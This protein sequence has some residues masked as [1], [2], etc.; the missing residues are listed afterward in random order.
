MVS[1]CDLKALLPIAGNPAVSHFVT[2]D[3]ANGRSW[4]QVAMSRQEEVWGGDSKKLGSVEQTTLKYVVGVGF[5][6]AEE[7]FR[8]A[9]RMG[10]AM[11][12]V[13]IL[14][15]QSEHFHRV[16]K[17]LQDP[18]TGLHRSQDWNSRKLTLALLVYKGYAPVV[19]YVA[20]YQRKAKRN[21]WA[22]SKL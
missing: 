22:S 20:N 3:Q 15:N 9:Q 14:L 17:C 2:K 13:Q 18:L 8:I 4:G 16:C 7:G 5:E 21:W 12:E 6:E 11:T 10:A 19:V 1:S